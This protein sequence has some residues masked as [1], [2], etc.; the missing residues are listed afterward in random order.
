MRFE[1]PRCR[2]FLA[3][4]MASVT[5]A[6]AAA[7]ADVQPRTLIVVNKSDSTVGLLDFASG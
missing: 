5:L 3:A 2:G 4:M 1:S 6:A 7:A